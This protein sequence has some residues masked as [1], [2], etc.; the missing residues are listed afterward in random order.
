MIYLRPDKT[1]YYLDVALIISERSTCLKRHYGAVIVKNDIIVSTGYNGNVRG[2][3][4]CC[5]IGYCQRAKMPRG[6]GYDSPTCS[7]HAEANA[8]I[9]AARKDMLDGDLYLAGYDLSTG[10]LVED[11]APCNQ[12]M[13]LIANAGIKTVYVRMKDKTVKVIDVSRWI[14]SGTELYAQNEQGNQ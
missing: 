13:R 4:N 11:P 14:I 7:V 2:M 5:D 10:E 1:N 8:I 6:V 9:A 3:R 12:C